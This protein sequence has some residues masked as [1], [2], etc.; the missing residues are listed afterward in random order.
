MCM[1]HA[2][3]HTEVRGQLVDAGSPTVYVQGTQYILSG[4]LGKCPYLLSS[5]PGPNGCLLLDHGFSEKFGKQNGTG[6]SNRHYSPR[7]HT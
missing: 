7:F 4:M 2:K 1:V 6:I 3:A 5:Q